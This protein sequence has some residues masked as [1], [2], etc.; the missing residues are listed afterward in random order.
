MLCVVL[1]SANAHGTSLLPSEK[2]CGPYHRTEVR[3]VMVAR[4]PNAAGPALDGESALRFNRGVIIRDFLRLR[5][6]RS[7]A[8]PDDVRELDANRLRQDGD[9]GRLTVEACAIV[10][11]MSESYA[12]PEQPLGAARSY[13]RGDSTDVDA[14][15]ELAPKPVPRAALQPPVAVVRAPEPVSGPPAPTMLAVSTRDTPAI[16]AA[17]RNARLARVARHVIDDLEEQLRVPPYLSFRE[18]RVGA[19]ERT[20]EE[21]E[22]Q[23]Q[24]S[25]RASER[26]LALL[27]SL[28][29]TPTLREAVLSSL[30]ADGRARIGE[31]LTRSFHSLP[32]AEPGARALNLWG[33]LEATALG[34][35]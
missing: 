3:Q 7:T 31:G 35:L 2:L 27:E 20:D 11:F 8:I 22:Q 32:E 6:E 14:A 33:E 17:E 12:D 23:R 4:N 18:A 25:L 34:R 1:P 28:T 24:A 9:G 30:G 16:D 19:R 15:P 26:V 21:V 29:R 5:A 13:L 10:H